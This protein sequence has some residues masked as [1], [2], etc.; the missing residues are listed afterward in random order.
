M[1][2][3]QTQTAFLTIDAVAARLN[4]SYSS[5]RKAIQAGRLPAYRFGTTYRVRSE[6]LDGFVAACR[7]A[8]TPPRSAP[9]GYRPLAN[10]SDLGHESWA[11]IWRQLRRFSNPAR[12]R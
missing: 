7:F 1:D 6:D 2:H 3:A 10:S 8:P 5:V 11:Q 12:L 9:S 4:L